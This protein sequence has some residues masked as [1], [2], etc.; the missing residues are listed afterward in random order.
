[1]SD[2]NVGDSIF[3]TLKDG[4][5]VTITVLELNAYGEGNVAFGVHDVHWRKPW[6]QRDTNAGG[7]RDCKM[8][9][10]FNGELLNLFPD[11]LVSV[12]SP[13]R[14]VQR[15]NGREYVS[16]DKLWAYS[17][18]EVFGTPDGTQMPDVGDMQFE[19]FKEK[20]NRVKFL[21][22]EPCRHA[23]RSPYV[24]TTSFFWSVGSNGDANNGYNYAGAN[25]SYGVCPCFIIYKQNND[26]NDG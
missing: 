8:R 25:N 18:T 19:F 2:L 21:N 9:E 4:T 17:Y 7:W 24:G 15:I 14:I 3:C 10:D 5:E 1:M 23:T 6:N 26:E 16:L 20:K 11:D 22:G 12:I 13:R